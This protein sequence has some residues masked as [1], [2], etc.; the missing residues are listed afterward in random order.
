[1]LAGWS[2]LPRNVW[3][4]S[5][6]NPESILERWLLEVC[7]FLLHRQQQCITIYSAAVAWDILISSQN[8]SPLKYIVTDSWPQLLI[9]FEGVSFFFINSHLSSLHGVN[10]WF[11]KDNFGWE[12]R[13]INSSYT[14]EN[15]FYGYPVL[16]GYNDESPASCWQ[17]VHISGCGLSTGALCINVQALSRHSQRPHRC[18]LNY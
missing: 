5:F 16:Q 15:V 4:Y 10:I 12:N 2:V 8:L 13:E 11:W 14:G 18:V 1:M 7:S 9:S 6:V 17:V 3:R